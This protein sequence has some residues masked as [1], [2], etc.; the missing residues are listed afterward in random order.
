MRPVDLLIVVA[1][2]VNTTAL[3]FRLAAT[4]IAQIL[5]SSVATTLSLQRAL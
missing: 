3:D 5:K 1:C 2:Y 4:A